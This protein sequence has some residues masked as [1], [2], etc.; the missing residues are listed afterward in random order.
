MVPRM[1][2]LRPLGLSR[3]VV[4]RAAFVCAL[5]APAAANAQVTVAVDPTLDVHP[6]SPLVYGMNFPS[7]AQVSQGKIPIMRRGGNATTRYN[8]EIDTYNTGSD[9][10]FENISQCLVPPCN[11]GDPKTNSA[12]NA[13]LSQGQTAGIPMLFTIPTIGY[14]A[15]PPPKYN[16]PFDCGCPKTSNPAQDAF[17]PFDTNCGNCQS[18]GHPITAPDPTTTTSIAITPQWAHDWVAYL[19]GKF[20]PSNGKVVYELD[21][22]PA[23]W[24]TTHHDVRP[25]PLGYDELWQRMRDYA[26]AIL[27]AD[28]TARVAGFQE[29]GWPNYF[30]SAVDTANGAGCSASSPDRAAHAGEELTAWILDQAAAYEQQHGQRILHFLDLHYYPQGGTPPATVRSLWDPTYVD[31]SWINST[32]ELIPRM[33]SWVSQHY[34]GTKIGISEYD[35]GNHNAAL[36]AITYAE[37]LGTF[38]REQLDYAT[39]WN[40][41][42]ETE[43]AF[44]AF[45][46]FT[47]YDGAGAHFQSTNARATVAGSGVQAYAAAG[48]S[49]MTVALV[50]ENASPVPMTVTLGSFRAG[51]TARY[52]ELGTGVTIARK[53]D[54]PIAGG[55]ATFTMGAS[56]IGMLVIDAPATAVPAMPRVALWALALLLCAGA[57]WATRRRGARL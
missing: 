8:Y 36:G 53:P 39:A 2:S 4:A 48:P 6:V 19:V 33:R 31:P 12:A 23:L 28:P 35:W 20:G 47:N 56:T 16:H 32:I 25:T 26:V 55:S 50:N 11:P 10:Y 49:Q 37:V 27:Q 52:Y 15:R 1:A 45:A 54:V 3:R 17:D 13:F 42:L 34:P 18:G 21:N 57:G 7:T 22:E 43:T 46:L 38:G 51:T 14:V 30:C 24:N 5:G 9:Y 40:P 29:W 44:A 41:P